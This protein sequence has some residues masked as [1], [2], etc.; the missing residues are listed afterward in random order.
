MG[1]EGCV[2]M[3]SQLLWTLLVLVDGE[4]KGMCASSQQLRTR[5]IGT[6]R[7]GLF[8]SRIS[9]GGQ[10]DGVTMVKY[11]CT[12]LW[13]KNTGRRVLSWEK[14]NTDGNGQSLTRKDWMTGAEGGARNR[15]IQQKEKEQKNTRNKEEGVFFKTG[16]DAGMWPLGR[17]SRLYFSPLCRF[18]SESF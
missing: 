10:E 1:G 8:S 9:R 4:E 17:G 2:R 15:R 6:A 11:T 5:C 18:V 7:F 13:E 12:Y 16:Q 3:S 14:E